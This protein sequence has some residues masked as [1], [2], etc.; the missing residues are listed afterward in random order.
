[1]L[2]FQPECL[3]F[4]KSP[5][6]PHTAVRKLGTSNKD[7]R[8]RSIGKS[9]VCTMFTSISCRERL[10]L[11]SF[12]KWSAFLTMLPNSFKCSFR[13]GKSLFSSTKFCKSWTNW[14]FRD[15]NNSLILWQLSQRDSSIFSDPGEPLCYKTWARNQN[16]KETKVVLRIVNETTV[17]TNRTWCFRSCAIRQWWPRPALEMDKH[18]MQNNAANRQPRDVGLNKQVRAGHT[19]TPFFLHSTLWE[20]TKAKDMYSLA[21]SFDSR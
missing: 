18:E 6:P 13:S 12:T 21:S 17:H 14:G 4:A 8:M 10:A 9:K 1:M 7:N 5:Y 16:K 3:F 19:W 15:F 2:C 20:D 11:S